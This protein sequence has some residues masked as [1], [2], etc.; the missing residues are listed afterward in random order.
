VLGKILARLERHDEAARELRAALAIWAEREVEN[1][2]VSETRFN[3]AIALW[4]SGGDRR[5]A[6]ALARRARK[7]LADRPDSVAAVETWLRERR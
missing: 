3:L 5:E 7:E 1:A 6:V 2:F 4:G